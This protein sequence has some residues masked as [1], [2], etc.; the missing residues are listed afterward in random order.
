MG[1]HLPDDFV[2]VPNENSANCLKD[3]RSGADQANKKQPRRMGNLV[4]NV[5]KNSRMVK[6]DGQLAQRKNPSGAAASDGE[7]QRG[8]STAPPIEMYHC[9]QEW[10]NSTVWPGTFPD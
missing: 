6:L 10:K 1:A 3:C 5:G 2:V 7:S 4:L 8:S 9:A